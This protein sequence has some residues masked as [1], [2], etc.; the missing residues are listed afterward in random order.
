MS[1]TSAIGAALATG[2]NLKASENSASG[3]AESTVTK[4]P[5]AVRAGAQ[6]VT[7]ARCAS[8]FSC[9]ANASY[10]WCQ[11]LPPLDLSQRPVDLLERG[12]LCL[13]CLRTAVAAQAAA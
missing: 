8:S 4:V 12:C 10:C 1:A 6:D 13:R 5:R 7:C 11:T 3:D 2:S 9:G